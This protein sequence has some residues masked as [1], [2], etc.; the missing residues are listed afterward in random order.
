MANLVNTL[1]RLQREIEGTGIA[2]Q[3]GE[4]QVRLA[5]PA[6][7][8]CLR[9]V[10]LY[11]PSSRDIERESASDVLLILTAPTQKAVRAAEKTNY[12]VI[13]GDNY[14]IVAPGVALIRETHEPTV[15]ASRQVRLMGRT[16]VL[17]ESLL[18]GGRRE[19]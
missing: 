1:A 14:R 7:S 12:V 6:G 8:S 2:F 16:G 17:A 3:L 18:L 5:G 10:S 4:D 15:E 19:W 9:I 11:R 13:P